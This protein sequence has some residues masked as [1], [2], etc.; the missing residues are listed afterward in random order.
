MPYRLATIALGPLLYLQG[1]A[2]RR[3]VPVLPEPDGA[4]EG[5][6]GT[7]PVLRLL[8][9]GDSAAAG[10]GVATMDQALSGQLVARLANAY[11]V[12]WQLVAKTGATTESALEHLEAQSLGPFDVS[13]TSLGVNDVTSAKAPS[14]WLRSQADLRKHL[15]ERIL[16]KHQITC[17]LPPMHGFPALPQ[18]LR[19]WLGARASAFDSALQ[20]AISTEPDVSFL[21]LRFTEDAS[22]MASDGFHP[23]AAVYAEWATRLHQIITHSSSARA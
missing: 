15:R 21:S 23:G 13:V 3:S 11:T 4:R 16:V 7:G 17:G 14:A 1:R 8:V 18:P 6:V 2:V 19:W 10:V 22:L 20:R 5:K 12:H 9:L